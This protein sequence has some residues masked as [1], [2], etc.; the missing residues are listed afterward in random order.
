M[1]GR[2]LAENLQAIRPELKVLFMSG[3]TADIIFKQG[4]VEEGIH[5]LQKPVSLK[6]L[7]KKVREILDQS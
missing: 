3:Y 2:E 1:N 6:K 4:I 5:F 7:T